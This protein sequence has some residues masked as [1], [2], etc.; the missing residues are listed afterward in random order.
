MA[1]RWGTA[2]IGLRW[3][4]IDSKM[5]ADLAAACMVLLTVYAHWSIP[6]Q[7]AG[8]ART[9]SAR[10]LLAAMGVVSGLLTIHVAKLQDA[11][12]L[13]LF[14]IGFGQVHVP[15]AVWLFLRAQRRGRLS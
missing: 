14:L 5:L 13:A 15:V 2:T 4:H 3:E 9:W 7:A 1:F 11:S 10:L 12:A 8:E 6:R